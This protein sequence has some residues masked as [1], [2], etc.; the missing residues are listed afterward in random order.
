MTLR[1]M[2]TPAA[3]LL[4]AAAVLFAVYPALRP[5]SSETGVE[6][7][8]AFASTAWT[9][10]HLC[11]I[12]GFVVLS[13]VTGRIGLPRVGAGLVS[14]G[15]TLVLP[16]YGA[17][18]FGV[19]AVGRSALTGGDLGLADDIRYGGAAVALFAGGLV[20]MAVGGVLLGIALW[21][22][23]ARAAGVLLAV[24]LVLYLPQFWFPPAGRVLHGVVLAAGLLLLALHVARRDRERLAG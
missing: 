24:G 3:A 11:G 13:Q 7:A 19:G 4:G 14:L 5:Y 21:R 6:G 18:V 10:S 17:E 23:S 2:P 16:Y 1:P 15:A 9:A 20:V 22:R 8:R 12:A